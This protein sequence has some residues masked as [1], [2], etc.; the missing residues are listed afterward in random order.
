MVR[1]MLINSSIMKE[2]GKNGKE[3]LRVEAF[4]P[5]ETYFA[6]K[7]QPIP[8]RWLLEVA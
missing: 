5:E 8:C 7:R 2:N 1:L 4:Q 3:K 6:Y